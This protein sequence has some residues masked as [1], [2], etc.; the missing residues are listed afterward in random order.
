MQ[1]LALTYDQGS[2]E[3]AIYHNGGRVAHENLGS[4]TADTAKRL[5]LGRQPPSWGFDGVLDELG[6]YQRALTSNE[7]SCDLPRGEL[8][9]MQTVGSTQSG[10]GHR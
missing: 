6:L 4:F 10:G 9:Q 3:T 8:G 7:D 1:H 5:V 2:G